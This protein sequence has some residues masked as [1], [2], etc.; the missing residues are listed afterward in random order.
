M[1]TKG[2]YFI[3]AFFM[4]DGF[5]LRCYFCLP[6]VVTALHPIIHLIDFNQFYI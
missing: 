2:S 1:N 5:V 6:V 3:G 4:P